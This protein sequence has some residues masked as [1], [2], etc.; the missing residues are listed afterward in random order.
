M[1]TFKDILELICGLCMIICPISIILTI[2]AFIILSAKL[3]VISFLTLC[4][5]AGYCFFYLTFTNDIFKIK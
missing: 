2:V 3:L 1:K 4:F 5:T